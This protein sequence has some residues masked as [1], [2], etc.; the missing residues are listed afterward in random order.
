MPWAWHKTAHRQA[1]HRLI[2]GG[3]TMFDGTSK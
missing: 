2:N 3:S 1:P